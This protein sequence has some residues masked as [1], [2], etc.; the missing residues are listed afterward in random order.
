[1]DNPER[2]HYELH[3]AVFIKP[4]AHRVRDFL[5]QRLLV[6]PEAVVQRALHVR[7]AFW[8]VAVAHVPFGST[9]VRTRALVRCK[10]HIPFFFSF[11]FFSFFS[12]FSFFFFSFWVC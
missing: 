8:R 10:S 9:V 5:T 12:F 2:S 11:F 4:R 1:V 7:F 3:D 6:V